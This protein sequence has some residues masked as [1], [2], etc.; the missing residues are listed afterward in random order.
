[1]ATVYVGPDETLDKALRRFQKVSARRR[2]EARQR[3]Y[4]L[5]KK[6]KQK[7]NR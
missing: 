7:L 1:M 6:E 3:Q 2:K 4:F 5:T